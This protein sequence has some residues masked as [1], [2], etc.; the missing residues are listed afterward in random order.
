MSATSVSEPRVLRRAIRDGGPW[1]VLLAAGALV[2]AAAELLLPAALGRAVDEALAGRPALWLGAAAGLVAVIAVGEILTDLAA[3]LGTAR[4]TA[5]LRHSLVRHVVALDLRQA[6]RYPGGDLVSRI[7]GQVAVAGQAGPAVVSCAAALV[8]S[9]GSVVALALIDPWLAGTFVAGLLVLAGLLRTYV[10]DLAGAATRYQRVQS[11]IATRFVEAVGGAR[12]IGAAGT[13]E[14]EIDRVLVPLP[15]LRRAGTGTWEAA[16]R[17]TARGAVAAPLV[18]IA[19]VAVGG[20]ALARGRLTPGEL[21]AALQYATLGAGLGAAVSELGRLA[22]SRAGSRRAAEIL[23][24]PAWRAGGDDLPPGPGRLELRAVT[25]CEHDRVVLDAVSLAVPGG[26]TVAVVGRSG[27]GKSTLAAVAGRLRDPD[28]GEVRLDGVPLHRLDTAALRAAVGYAFARPVL[29]GGTVAGAITLGAPASPGTV[30]AAART[31]CVD[32]VVER[33]PA[34]YATPLADA[35]FSGG[36]EQRL[37]LA[38]A[39]RATRLLVLDDATSSLDTVTEYQIGR[40]LTR[41]ADRRT[42]LVVTHR[43]ATAARADLVAWLDGGRLRGY[44]PHAMLWRDPAY[45]DMFEAPC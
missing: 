45:R 10:S 3:G 2:A 40:A 39:L 11:A 15:D 12:T 36:E 44:A 7:V 43:V 20:L 32:A 6:G 27:A 18:Q 25:V 1:T 37:G 34:G 24:V 5:R 9:L 35:P 14:R 22:R 19:V 41:A 38:R 23:G 8:P 13:V 33:L 17:A 21:L 4:A 28:A 31:A 16:G 30:R 29:I 42:R 26:A